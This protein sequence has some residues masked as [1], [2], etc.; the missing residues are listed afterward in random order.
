MDDPALSNSSTEDD[1]V[2]KEVDRTLF[3]AVNF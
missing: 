1:E 2:I 3:G